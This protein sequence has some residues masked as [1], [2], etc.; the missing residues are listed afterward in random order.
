M[1]LECVLNR[2]AH[3]AR[4]AP[5]EETPAGAL[6]WKLKQA[7]FVCRGSFHGLL[8]LED[9]RLYPITRDGNEDVFNWVAP[10]RWLFSVFACPSRDNVGFNC[11]DNVTLP[12]INPVNIIVR[13]S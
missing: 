10:H 4:R 7:H 8:R 6:G 2:R 1:L 13:S 11:Y 5:T 12:G 3:D 9:G